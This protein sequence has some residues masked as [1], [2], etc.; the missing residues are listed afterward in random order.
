[1]NTNILALASGLAVSERD[2][3]QCAFVSRDGL[4]CTERTF[5]EF[6]HI[7]PYALGGEATVEN[8]SLRCRRHNQYEAD[9]VFGPY[10]VSL[11]RER[12]RADWATPMM[13]G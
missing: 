4:R 12:P 6:H 7:R 1:M 10:G 3:D 5:L 9:L 2:S 13:C 11:V 8:I